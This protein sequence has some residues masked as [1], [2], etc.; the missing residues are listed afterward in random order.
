MQ[1]H[2]GIPVFLTKFHSDQIVPPVSFLRRVATAAKELSIPSAASALPRRRPHPPVGLSN[3]S[4]AIIQPHQGSGKSM[5]SVPTT[6]SRSPS[7][8]RFVRRSPNTMRA[9]STVTTMLS[10][11]I[12]TTTL[13]GPVW[14]A[15]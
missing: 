9:N 14:S 6:I 11:S 1:Q 15:R 8:A 5:P 13:A 2:D 4:L 12:G 10:L 7:A 3:A